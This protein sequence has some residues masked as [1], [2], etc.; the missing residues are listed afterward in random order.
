MEHTLLLSVSRGFRPVIPLSRTSTLSLSLSLSNSFSLSLSFSLSPSLILSLSLS[1]SLSLYFYIFTYVYMKLYTSP[2]TLVCTDRVPWAVARL[3][4]GCGLLPFSVHLP[5]RH[6]LSRQ[7]RPPVFCTTD[8]LYY[9]YSGLPT[10]L[11]AVPKCALALPCL[12]ARATLKRS[13]FEA[14]IEKFLRDLIK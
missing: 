13:H 12:V 11:L 10:I 5:L 1:L 14:W 9:R 6:P 2:Y 8:N 4:H 7:P 3:R